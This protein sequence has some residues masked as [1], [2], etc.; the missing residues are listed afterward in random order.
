MRMIGHVPSEASASVFSHFLGGQGIANEIEAEKEGWA[1]WIHSEDE[2]DKARE[3]L[4]NF[5]GNPNDPKYQKNLRAAEALKRHAPE[6]AAV[7]NKKYFDRTRLFSSRLRL[8]LGPFTFLLIFASVTITILAGLSPTEDF[9]NNFLITQVHEEGMYVKWYPGLPEIAHGQ[10][11]RF[12]TPILAHDDP[13]RG[14]PLHLLFDMVWLFIFGTMIE[15]RQSTWRLLLLV[16]T[17]A[18]PS[19]LA[20]YFMSGPRFFGMS[21]VVYG[22]FGY[23]WMKGKYDPDSGYYIQ[24]QTIVM[25]L[26]WF[27]LCLFKVIPNIANTVHAVGLAVGVIW[28]FLSSQTRL[29]NRSS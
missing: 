1:V 14:N 19:N 16:L 4:L 11:W 26:I 28:G 15:S 2:L 20:E 12:F 21:G 9:L 10:I 5:L 7:P 18:A 23:I 27:F 24:P 25:M 29:G 6:E 8:G 13:F 3:L 17:I 22:L